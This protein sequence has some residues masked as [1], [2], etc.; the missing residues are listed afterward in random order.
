VASMHHR[1]WW[2]EEMAA[3]A[4]AHRMECTLATRSAEVDS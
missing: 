1:V 4:V 3:A 2:R